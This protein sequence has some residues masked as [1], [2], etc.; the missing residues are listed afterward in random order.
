M[1]SL[2]LINQYEL[3]ASLTGKMRVAANQGEWERVIELEAQCG[4]NIASMQLV[5]LNPVLDKIS[6]QRQR[7]L[8]QQIIADNAAVRNCTE[9]WMMQMKLNL[10]SN[11]QEQRINQAY[12]AAG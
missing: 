11:R 3:L 8:I 5:E 7:Q 2:Q 1:N 4:L 6:Q 10:Q 9:S 12:G